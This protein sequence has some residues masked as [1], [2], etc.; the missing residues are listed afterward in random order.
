MAQLLVRNLP[1]DVKERIRQRAKRHG[2]SLEAEARAILEDIARNERANVSKRDEEG[3]GTR[4]H[5]R[6]AKA[7]LT[8]AEA[9]LFDKA[10]EDLRRSSKPRDTGIK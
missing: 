6:F 7:G 2:R 5:R 1:D 3:F 9:A 10:I 4:M 8:K